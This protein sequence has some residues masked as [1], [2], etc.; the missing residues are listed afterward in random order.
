MYVCM[1]VCM[2]VYVYIYIY[3]YIERDRHIVSVY[4]YIYIYIYT[5]KCS[6][7]TLCPR[8][9]AASSISI[10]I[11]ISLSLSLSLALYTYIYIYIYIPVHIMTIRKF[12]TK[13]FANEGLQ[14]RLGWGA[15]PFLFLGVLLPKTL[16]G[17]KP[18]NDRTR[19]PPRYATCMPKKG[20]YIYIYIYV[21]YLYDII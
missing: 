9:A 4:T 8:G 2:Y 19:F 20:M 6:P 13:D 15:L 11:S 18:Q 21:Y 12:A 10:S 3:I 17:P 1:Y 7:G 16:Q 5:N 14:N